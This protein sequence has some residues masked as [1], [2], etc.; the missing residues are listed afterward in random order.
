MNML[1]YFEFSC[2]QTLLNIHMN[3][4]LFCKLISN[5]IYVCV[6]VC[7]FACTCVN[8]MSN[9]ISPPPP[10]KLE[11]GSAASFSRWKSLA[12]LDG[13]NWGI[14]RRTSILRLG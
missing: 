4:F 8:V 13:E 9:V 11:L 3:E 7:V 2:I 14:Y 12:S 10:L 6:C 5:T 1:F